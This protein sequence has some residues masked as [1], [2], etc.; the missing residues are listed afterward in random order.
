METEGKDLK[1]VLNKDQSN[2]K[3]Q[4][5]GTEKGTENEQRNS[6]NNGNNN[7][8]KQ[9]MNGEKLTARTKLSIG[10]RDLR[11]LSAVERWGILGVGQLNNLALEAEE[12]GE[13]KARLIFNETEKRDYWTRLYKRVEQ[14]RQAGYLQ[15]QHQ[16]KVYLLTEKG[17]E[18]LKEKGAARLRF[19]RNGISPHLVDH[20]LLVA[21]AGMLIE[22]FLGYKARPVR[23]RGGMERGGW[24][25]APRRGIPDL[26][27]VDPTLPKA[28]EVELNGKGQAEY[29]QIWAAYRLRLRGGKGVVLYLTTMPDGVSTILQSARECQADFVYACD[30]QEFRRSLG[31]APFHGFQ[32]GRRIAIEPRKSP[33]HH[34]RLEPLDSRPPAASPALLIQGAQA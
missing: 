25:P 24:R 12:E 20:E 5:L 17:H 8:G 30:M 3:G 2:F 28:V 32:E 26:W 7:K 33:A 34:G 11:I 22:E 18:H 9:E 10:E 16:P 13:E 19:F 31:R 21:A 6:N 1:V 23:E 15:A 4:E 29:E 14:L 27:V